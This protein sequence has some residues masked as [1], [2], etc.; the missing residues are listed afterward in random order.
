MRK[1]EVDYRGLTERDGARQRIPGTHSFSRQQSVSGGPHIQ[2]ATASASTGKTQLL[3][4]SPDQLPINC[5]LLQGQLSSSDSTPH[6][7]VFTPNHVSNPR[8]M[9]LRPL[10]ILSMNPQLPPASSSCISQ[11]QNQQKP[12]HPAFSPSKCLCAA[13]YIKQ[14][15]MKISV[16]LWW[17]VKLEGLLTSV[18]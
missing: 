3:P 10:S 6:L 17:S 2:A 16:N 1:G 11:P 18:L 9:T 13:P 12:S 8:I 5:L 4:R 15:S 14:G 7:T